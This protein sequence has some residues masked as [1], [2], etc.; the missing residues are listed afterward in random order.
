Q[1]PKKKKD[2]VQMKEINA[3]TEH[4]YGDVNIQMTSYDMCLVEH[5]AQYVHKLCNRLGVKV[6]ESYAMPTKTNEVLYLEERGSKM[7]LD[8]VLTT[9]QRVV[10]V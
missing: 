3:G 9:H 10:Q 2:K 5:F 4:E 6:N 8:A 7:Q 1:A